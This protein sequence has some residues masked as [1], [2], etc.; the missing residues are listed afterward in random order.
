MPDGHDAPRLIDEL[1][2]G[3]AAVIDDVAVGSED[4]VGEP[5]FANELP[6]ILDRVEFGTIGRQRDD[7][8]VPGTSSLPVMCHPA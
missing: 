4:P 2:P 8:D 7:A 6:D 1:V 3:F 5:V